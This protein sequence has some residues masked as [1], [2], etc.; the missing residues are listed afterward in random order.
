MTIEDYCRYEIQATCPGALY[1]ADKIL[2]NKTVRMADE[3]SRRL[4]SH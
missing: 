3:I 2:L 1:S 4:E